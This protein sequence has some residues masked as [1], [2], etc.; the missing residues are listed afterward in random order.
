MKFC[1]IVDNML[2]RELAEFL[3][4]R[5]HEARTVGRL[6]TGSNS[7][8]SIWAKTEEMRGVLITKDADFDFII[9]GSVKAQLVHYRGGNVTT[10]HLL[11][12][13]EKNLPDILLGLEAGELKIE[14]R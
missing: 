6:K 14:F 4:S 13:F 7:D 9:K 5:G 12:V 1:F 10:A 2:P 3:I 8:G 11:D